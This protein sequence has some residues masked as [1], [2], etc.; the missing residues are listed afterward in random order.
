MGA[1]MRMSIARGVL[2]AAVVAALGATEVVGATLAS[3]RQHY[4]VVA[5]DPKNHARIDVPLGDRLE[6]RLKACE[7]C[8]FRWKFVKKP[9]S[10]VIAFDR[11]LSSR[12]SCTPPCTGGNVH[13]RFLFSSKA[14]GETTVKLGYFGPGKDKPTKVKPLR[15]AVTG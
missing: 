6:L 14:A 9:D 8:G 1:K 3:A 11:R 12:G 7:D 10:S 2:V 4:R 13:E 15:L 5:T